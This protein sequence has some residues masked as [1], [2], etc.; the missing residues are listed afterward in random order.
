MKHKSR[1]KV[2]FFFLGQTSL[3]SFNLASALNFPPPLC[4]FSLKKQTLVKAADLFLS[5]CPQ[6]RAQIC[7]V[8]ELVYILG[9]LVTKCKTAG[10]QTSQ[11]LRRGHAGWVCCRY[12]ACTDLPR[13][14]SLHKHQIIRSPHFSAHHHYLARQTFNPGVG[15][16]SGVLFRLSLNEVILN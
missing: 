14:S 7:S 11:R 15:K 9:A 8:W 3:V 12:A 13:S 6:I 10:G 1:S 4:A 16:W 5:G 2:D